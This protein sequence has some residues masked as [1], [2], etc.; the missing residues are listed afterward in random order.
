MAHRFLN[1]PCPD[2]VLFAFD[3]I[4]LDLVVAKPYEICPSA[5]MVMTV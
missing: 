4:P 3:L 5:C 1:R 2:D